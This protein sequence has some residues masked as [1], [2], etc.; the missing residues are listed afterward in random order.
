M[1]LKDSSSIMISAASCKRLFAVMLQLSKP[2]A[3][4]QSTE[5]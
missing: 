3:F 2:A 1:A 5:S 4:E